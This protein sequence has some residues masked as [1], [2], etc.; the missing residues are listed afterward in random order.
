MDYP[1]EIVSKP[2]L[3][4]FVGEQRPLAVHCFLEDL[5]RLVL[6]FQREFELVPTRRAD[7][8]L[9]E[10]LVV[11]VGQRVPGLPQEPGH[12]MP[13]VVVHF[14]E[15]PA[16][17]QAKLVQ[18]APVNDAPLVVFIVEEAEPAQDQPQV[19]VQ[20]LERVDGEVVET[21]PDAFVGNPA[22]F[23]TF[24]HVIQ[25]EDVRVGALGEFCRNVL[26]DQVIQRLPASGRPQLMDRLAVHRRKAR[27][28]DRQH[29]MDIRVD[30]PFVS[31]VPHRVQKRHRIED[32]PRRPLAVQ[33]IAKEADRLVDLGNSAGRAC[34]GRQQRRH[35]G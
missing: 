1:L 25:A 27:P 17:A 4:L 13:E 14:A 16:D 24:V 34:P 5:K 26:V 31:V 30:G 6:D 19:V 3:K 9:S 22:A 23:E 12:Q 18:R 2:G 7:S 10:R 21:Q 32:V 20:I 8:H 33:R 29:L 35:S 28:A 15:L 11:F